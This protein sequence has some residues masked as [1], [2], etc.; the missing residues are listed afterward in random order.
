MRAEKS[1]GLRPS[2]RLQQRR[3]VPAHRPC[4]RRET[5]WAKAETERLEDAAGD[6]ELLDGLFPYLQQR[7]G[8]PNI[9]ARFSPLVDALALSREQGFSPCEPRG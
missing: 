7:Y 1:R 4:V 3:R 2:E 5:G 9:Q 8:L 6:A